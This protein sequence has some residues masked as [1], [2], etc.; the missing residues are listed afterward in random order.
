MN[1]LK[2]TI[3]AHFHAF[4]G[5]T[6]GWLGPTEGVTSFSGPM[7]IPFKLNPDPPNRP[8]ETDP[9]LEFDSERP[10]VRPKM[11]SHEPLLRPEPPEV[12]S[13]RMDFHIAEPTLGLGQPLP[14]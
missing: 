5:W 11:P 6:G 7:A 13:E 1:G 12:R 8:A 4:V 9:F 2:L 14:R 3:H 10:G